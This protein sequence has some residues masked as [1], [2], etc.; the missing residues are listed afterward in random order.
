MAITLLAASPAL[1]VTFTVD[2]TA[3]LIDAAPG[4]GFC[5]AAGGAC[6]LRAAVQEANALS[7]SDLVRLPAGLF[8]LT[9]AG[10]GENAAATGDL[11]VSENLTLQGETETLTLLDAAQLDR[12]FEIHPGVGEVR[13]RLVDLT[14]RGGELGFGADGGCILNPE[15]GRVELLRVTV[16]GCR[17]LRSGCGVF[18][19]GLLEGVDVSIVDCGDVDPESPRVWGGGIANVGPFAQVSLLRCEIRGSRA[20]N[21]G[22]VYTSAEFITPH[23]SRVRLEQCSLID[24]QVLQNGGA[25]LLNSRTH[26]ELLDTT[27]S[28]NVAGSG[29]G[30][31]N[32]GGGIYEI[33]GSTIRANHAA[34]IGG[35]ISEVH[36]HPDFI[37][38]SNS[39]IAGNT[40]DFFGPDCNFRLRSEGA[41][42]IGDTASCQPTTG[43]GDLLDVDP[44]LGSLTQLAPR[45][46]AHLPR[47]G[48]PVV[49]TGSVALC[50]PADQTATPRPLDGDGD[51]QSRC[52]IGA[53][54]AAGPL[55][56]SGFETGDTSEWSVVV[57]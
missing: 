7:G 12:V 8:E 57:P 40:A 37:L 18:N 19:G 56:A 15:D 54:E 35:G 39:V 41:T 55:F 48:S 26:V 51:G 34:N 46:W 16:Q 50:T 49:D 28:S 29:G 5:Q 44:Q 31:F 21:G 38:V 22:A 11:D 24:N 2:T 25:I 10:T 4:D 47:P 52:D 33:R 43:P 53:I 9:I 1:A 20:Q 42:L 13:L 6:S 36:F 17:C 23:D 30:I 14:V 32:D 3:D 27:I 45:V